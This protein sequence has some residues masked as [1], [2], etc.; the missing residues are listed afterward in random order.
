M[1]HRPLP[2]LPP[3]IIEVTNPT[4][5]HDAA[6]AA[7]E[8]GYASAFAP[9]ALSAGQAKV[10][11]IENAITDRATQASDAYDKLNTFFTA[12]AATINSVSTAVLGTD[13]KSIESAITHFAE[14]SAVVMKGLDALG[15]VHPFIGVAVGAFKLVISFDITR[16][17][18]NKKVL[19]VKL[20]MQDMMTVLFQLRNVR[21]PTDKGPDGTPL[22]ERMAAVIQA[23]ADDITSCGSACDV[24]IKKSFIAKTLKS[25]IYESRLAGYASK[26]EEHKK[27]IKFELQIH[28]ALGVDAANQK[29][30]SAQDH[31]VSLEAKMEAIFRKLDTPK[32]R[33][34]RSYVEERGGPRVCIEAEGGID[35][36]VS[37]SGESMSVAVGGGAGGEMTTTEAKKRLVKELAEDVD[38]A[39]RKNMKLFDRK[40]EMQSR[41][42]EDAISLTGEHIISALEDGTHKRLVDQDLQELWREQ[43]WKGS[44]KARH[45]VLALNDYYTEKFSAK[46]IA[47][48]A[49]S[50]AG[51]APPSPIISPVD[52][53]VIMP[54]P[55]AEDDRWAL[56]YINVAHMQPILEAF[57]DDGTGFVSVKEANDFAMMKPRG[58]SLLRWVAFWAAGWHLSVTWYKN[59]IY[60][61]LKTMLE[62]IPHVSAGNVNA[63]GV[64]FACPGMRRVELLL[65]STKSAPAKDT[66]GKDEGE[67][68]KL[69]E[70]K[71][72]FRVSEEKRLEQ[73]LSRLLYE[74]DDVATV[75]L[76]TGPRRIE[77]YIYPLLFLM[78]K[79]H[80]DIMRLACVH[81]L[82]DS[83]WETMA[84]SLMNIMKVVDERT[85]SL[86]VI[87]RSSS[88]DV[89]ERFGNFAFGMFQ[90][91]YG[92]KPRD[93]AKNTIVSFSEEDG[94]EDPDED[95]AP[96]WDE[97]DAATVKATLARIQPDILHAEIQDEP[98]NVYNFD[99]GPSSPVDPVEGLW[100]GQLVESYGTA[101]EGT[102]SLVLTRTGDTI[103]GT[104]ENYLGLLDVE[105]T[106]E[107]AAAGGRKLK[108]NITWSDGYVGECEGVYDPV[109]ETIKGT[110]VGK[111]EEEEDGS[112][113]DDDEE[114]S[115]SGSGS[116]SGSEA[117]SD[118]DSD[119]SDSGSSSGS[120][121]SSDSDSPATFL[122]RRTPN[123]A[124]RFRYTDEEFAANAARAR[125][126]FA[127]SATLE[128]VR[129][130]RMTWAYF[131]Q[132]AEERKRI[133]ALT[134][135]YFEDND[136]LTPWTTFTDDEY[137]E[138]AA[139]NCKL[140]SCDA[141]FYCSAARFELQKVVSF[142]SRY[143]DSCER[144]IRGSMQFCIECIDDSFY[145][146]IDLCSLHTT[147]TPRTRRFV[148]QREHLMVKIIRRIQD[149]DLAWMVPEA[150]A[151]AKRV[152]KA[153]LASLPKADGAASTAAAHVTKKKKK[154][155]AQVCAC[156]GEAPAPPFFACIECEGDIV[157]CAD[158]ETKQVNALPD[159]RS[160]KHALS[161][162]LVYIHDA[163]AR[164]EEAGEDKKMAE[165]ETKLSA[166]DSKIAQ[167]EQKLET[168]LT[169]LETI[170]MG[171]GEKLSISA[172]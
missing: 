29:L 140:R 71:E 21:N 17:Q 68:S 123:A 9:E 50:V 167:L 169:S 78:L 94:Y 55:F 110:W 149:A 138:M 72:E 137:D 76:V 91:L 16:R 79:R 10:D 28:T 67:Y 102:L 36:L 86:E 107:N 85:K 65:R 43:G 4:P 63:A 108:I 6:I 53:R 84:T 103:R 160:P 96:K 46:D 164:E 144:E 172:A 60:N 25:K 158:C 148:H 114:A 159:G 133:L 100:V 166:L 134:K 49:N 44:V 93:P 87:L 153:Y 143:C 157:V 131:Q 139:L 122:F 117:G 18:N 127:I 24:Y 119:G 3:P 56:S 33:D 32:E 30:D 125:W 35:A 40:L 95:L 58:W 13:V 88:Q 64:Y 156:C 90:S 171:I 82:D 152:R 161:H 47:S 8:K 170:L 77:R 66:F 83:E 74:L 163:K 113:S 129:Q 116:E 34:A 168:K 124:F 145:E 15:Q 41:Q 73:R 112:D 105:G 31:L 45:F 27:Q 39:F 126:K 59:R 54:D 81:I 97:D 104:A 19:A 135:R 80:F 120:S 141:R 48:A 38:E 37:I 132:R 14:T 42:L 101:W 136:G 147:E 98:K 154:A 128:E 7:V 12:N 165:M 70:S 11:K 130:T 92:S 109:H 155:T 51:S 20:Q 5:G 57:D 146:S 69:K 150:R 1:A 142:G 115:G 89:A 99:A 26:F 22:Q 106:V 52:G 118:D 75:R 111:D 61:L 151:V 2:H 62:I 162:A 121:S 23:I